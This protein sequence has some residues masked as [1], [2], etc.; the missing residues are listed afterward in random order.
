MGKFG[1]SEV[2]GGGRLRLE[3]EQLGLRPPCEYTHYYSSYT[4]LNFFITSLGLHKQHLTYSN[5]FVNRL[6]LLIHRR[7]MYMYA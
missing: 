3:D 1:L 6:L 7:N 4:K 5:D 2:E